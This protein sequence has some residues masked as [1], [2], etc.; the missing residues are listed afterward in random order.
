MK[1]YSTISVIAVIAF[2]LVSCTKDSPYEKSIMN[3]EGVINSS[4]TKVSDTG[5]ENS[6]QIGVFVTDY[7]GTT[8]GSLSPTTN[9]GTNVKHTYSSSSDIWTP[10][11]GKEIYWND[12]VTKVDVYG[13]YP[14]NSS[15]TS[16]TEYPFSVQSD[17]ST[18]LNYFKSD[19][20]WAKTSN[21]T[22]QTFPVTLT[23]GHK[24][25]K[26]VITTTAGVGFTESEFNAATKSVEILGVKLNSKINLSNGAVSVDNSVVNGTITPKASGNV[27]TAI[28]V[29]QTVSESTVFIK[30]TVNGVVY[31]YSKGFTFES[32]KQYNFTVTVNKNSLS[33]VS[34]SVS[35]W[36][37]DGNVYS[38]KEEAINK[39]I[40]GNIYTTVKI[41]TQTWMKENLKTTK[42]RNGDPI[43][44]TTPATLDVSAETSPKY[45]W[46]YAGNESNASTYGR[47]YTW[48]AATDSRG[49]C[50]TGWHVPTD[51]EWTTLTSLLGGETGAG[52]YLKET[53][54]S[55]WYS[56]NTGA[57]NSTG[58]TALGGGYRVDNGPFS[59][60]G[61]YG[62]WWTST[63]SAVNNAWFRFMYWITSDVNRNN[64]SKAHGLS[65]RCIR[66]F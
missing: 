1:K 51:A 16:I 53:G 31:Y 34:N 23:F 60:I 43:G 12:A 40:D 20:L 65:I 6:D 45:Q 25:S 22:A 32:N 14:Y 11:A 13:Y 7:S 29:P 5:F 54:T 52:A 26:I 42:Y 59:A 63:E 28:L 46:A 47:L 38:V 18:S 55:H 66:D 15:V 64:G 48:Y 17:Q 27:F 50:P 33:V 41:G 36:T 49:I 58:F 61:S 19:F 44:T 37:T 56:P 3:I 4:I 62:T 35:E 39:D 9:H 8:P 2:L 10:E 24:M 21:V 57:T 30:A